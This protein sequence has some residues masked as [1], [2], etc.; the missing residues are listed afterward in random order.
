MDST[1]LFRISPHGLY[2]Q[3][4]LYS[5]RPD[6]ASRDELTGYSPRINSLHFLLLSFVHQCSEQS[7]IIFC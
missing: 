6:S 2:F 1:P 3:S 7:S 5:H 4:L